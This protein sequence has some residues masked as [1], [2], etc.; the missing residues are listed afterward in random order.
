M[1]PIRTN[2][3]VPIPVHAMLVKMINEIKEDSY[4][5][6][7][8]SKTQW[9][10]DMES[11]SRMDLPTSPN[12][13]KLEM[14]CYQSEIISS[15]RSITPDTGYLQHLQSDNTAKE[16]LDMWNMHMQGF[17]VELFQQRKEDLFDEYNAFAIGKRVHSYY[18]ANLSSTSATNNS[19]N[20]V[21]SN[22]NQILDNV[23]YQLNQEMHQGEHLDSDAETEIDE[24]YDSRNII[25][26]LTS[27]PTMFQLEQEADGLPAKNSIQTSTQT[28]LIQLDGLKVEHVSLQRRYD[29]LS[30]A[31]THSRTAN[32]E[33]LSAL[34]AEN[35]KL[36]AQVTGKTSSG[37][38]TSEKPKV[39]A[40]GIYNVG[41]QQ[42]HD[43]NHQCNKTRSL[44]FCEICLQENQTAT[45]LA[46]PLSQRAPLVTNVS[47]LVKVEERRRAA[48]HIGT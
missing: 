16:I 33:K 10:A 38:S 45:E 43:R 15:S 3:A 27:K 19:V 41:L 8:L 5:Q 18:F 47:G 11:P 24:Q 17:Q 31:N 21:H 6:V 22:D 34:T 37:P 26:S 40:S 14:G 20:E 7:Q 32:T 25:S 4:T 36:K 29:E 28:V 23:D 44:K 46:N 35:T 13:N 42:T 12:E 2:A 9:Q 30:K 1:H 39:L 48:I